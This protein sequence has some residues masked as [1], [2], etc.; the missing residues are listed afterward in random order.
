DRMTMGNGSAFDV[1]DIFAE[2]EFLSDRERHRRKGLVDFDAL[3][4]REFPPG[5]FQRLANRRDWPEAEH[6]G[7]NG[8]NTIR[9][10]TRHRFDRSG[11]RNAAIRDNHRGSA[12]VEPGSVAGRDGSAFAE[13]GTELGEDLGRGVGPWC[14]V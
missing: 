12:A 2:A 6:A 3:Y 4:V 13:S 7:F 9:D 11:L 10:Q 14:F 5:P 8:R 1:N